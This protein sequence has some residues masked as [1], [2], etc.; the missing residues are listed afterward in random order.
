MSWAIFWTALAILL[1]VVEAM[2]FGLTTIWFVVGALLALLASWIGLNVYIQVIIFFGASIG[3]LFITR[4]LV[5]KYLR[6]G[7]VKTN[8]D[9][10]IGKRGI[11]TLPIDEHNYGQVKL[12]GQMWTAKGIDTAHYNEG[13]EVEVVSIEG[14]K[15]VVKKV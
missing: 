6:A 9:S 15:L 7:N 11:V 4:P 1:A 13:L 8:V 2:T 3:L 12:A 14:V 5:V 10:L